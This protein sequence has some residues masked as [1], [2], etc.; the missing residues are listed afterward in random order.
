MYAKITTCYFGL[1]TSLF[2]KQ[3]P[4]CLIGQWVRNRNVNQMS[5]QF[6]SNSYSVPVFQTATKPFR[7]LIVNQTSNSS[8]NERKNLSFRQFPDFLESVNRARMCAKTNY[9][10]N[11]CCLHVNLPYFKIH[12]LLSKLI[13]RPMLCTNFS[14]LNTCVVILF[15]NNSE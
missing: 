3:R 2:C 12:E 1:T 4:H 15:F 7:F 8:Q 9:Y 6:Q 5:E 14:L 11:I 13:S 10:Y